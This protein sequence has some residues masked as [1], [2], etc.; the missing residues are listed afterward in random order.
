VATC[1]R[2]SG[3]GTGRVEAAVLADHLDLLVLNLHGFVGSDILA[4]RRSICF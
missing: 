3:E 1:A 2:G 4:V